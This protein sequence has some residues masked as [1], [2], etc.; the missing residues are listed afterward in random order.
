M[1]SYGKARL[2]LGALHSAGNV[3]EAEKTEVRDP[4]SR[5][6]PE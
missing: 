5:E 4:T 2:I 1:L 3:I 6:R